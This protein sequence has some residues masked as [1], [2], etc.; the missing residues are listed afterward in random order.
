MLEELKISK[1]ASNIGMGFVGDIVKVSLSNIVKLLSGV[2]IAFLLPK[3]IGVTDYGYYKVFTL[4]ATY[5]G[6]FH[7]G[8]CDGIYLKYG[9]SDYQT[10][11]KTKFRFYSQSFMLIEMIVALIVAVFSLVALEGEYE[12]IGLSLAFYIVFINITGF[13]QIVS[14][15]TR[16]FKELSFRNVLQSGLLTVSLLILAVLNQGMEI[17]ISYRVFTAIYISVI[18]FLAFWY[19]YTYRDLTFGEKKSSGTSFFEVFMLSKLG[20]SLTLAN[21]CASLILTIDRQAVLLLFDID[22]Y[23]QYA[24]AYNMLSLVTTALTAISTVIYPSLKRMQW[25]TFI[26]LHSKLSTYIL[27]LVFGCLMMYFP[28]AIFVQWYLPDFTPSLVYFEIVFPG[29]ALSSVLSIVVHNYYKTLGE[30][31]RYFKLTVLM[32]VLSLVCAL[33]AYEIVRTPESLSVSSIVVFLIWYVLAEGY[34]VKRF[35]FKWKK[36]AAYIALLM[37]VFYTVVEQ[38]DLGIAFVSYLIAYMVITLLLFRKEFIEA[39]GKVGII[40]KKSQMIRKD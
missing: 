16:R 1:L 30:T 25:D 6:L 4:Y 7:L 18:A 3:I 28:L 12:F 10:L 26:G 14:Q 37:M 2:L 27:L 34:L 9:G 21:V 19:I 32:I 11:D 17:D 40:T 5:M 15:V 39:I 20:I 33:L 36:N 24:F 22:T 35:S 29:I 23:A 31:A 38:F 13:Y 8:I